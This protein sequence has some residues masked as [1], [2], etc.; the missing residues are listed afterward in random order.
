MYTLEVIPNVHQVTVRLANMFLITEKKMTLIDA[1]YPGSVPYLVECIRKL[2]R[3]PEEIELVIVTHNHPDHTGSITE[4]REYADFKIAVHS[5][6]VEPSSN[7]LPYPVGKYIGG[8]FKTRLLSRL[9]KRL[10]LDDN[11][12]DIKLQDN[13]VLDILGGLQIVPTPGHTPGSISL[14]A[15]KFKILFVGDALGKR[16][17][18]LR[19]PYRP[20]SNDHQQAIT[21]VRRMAELDVQTL[22][23]GHGH[24]ITENVNSSLGR[25]A[26][27][28]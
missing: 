5:A 24:P 21:S 2:G 1:G 16:E 18:H 15:S 7:I 14:Y 26:A 13:Q 8:L 6:D 12:V 3:S 19:L 9:R 11:N 28:H 20:I 17:N 10:I 27:K 4:L 23:F 22:C 25:L